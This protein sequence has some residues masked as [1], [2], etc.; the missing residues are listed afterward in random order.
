MP[1]WLPAVAAEAILIAGVI[2]ATA[3]SP[4]AYG[5]GAFSTVAQACALI[6]LAAALQPAIRRVA[7]PR[8]PPTACRSCSPADPSRSATQSTSG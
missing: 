7:V 4:A 3:A 1:R 2:T 5:T 6:A 8:T